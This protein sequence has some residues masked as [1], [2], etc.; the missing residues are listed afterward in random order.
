MNC[1]RIASVVCTLLLLV[2]L[3]PVIQIFQFT[4]VILVIVS[5]LFVMFLVT[6]KIYPDNMTYRLCVLRAMEN[7]HE[8]IQ[9]RLFKDP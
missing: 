7:E 1:A 6:R 9:E 4:A 8:P 5:V 3:V 2:L